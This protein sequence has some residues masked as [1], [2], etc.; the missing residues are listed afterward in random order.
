MEDLAEEFEEEKLQNA[1]GVE[2]TR[3]LDEP[4]QEVPPISS[5]LS[6]IQPP[7]EPEDEE[8]YVAVGEDEEEPRE[9]GESEKSEEDDPAIPRIEESLL[10]RVNHVF[11]EPPNYRESLQKLREQI[12]DSHVFIIHGDEHAGKLTCALHLA[13]DLLNRKA[14]EKRIYCYRRR[15][16]ELLSLLD[17][18][19]QE[20]VKDG[21]VYI[22]EDAFPSVS[23]EDLE[24]PFLH[25]LN[26]KLQ[27][28]KS[29]LLLTTE[30]PS[31]TLPPGVATV[32]VGVRDLQQVFL[33]H[34]DLY[35]AD[36]Y[37]VDRVRIEEP[38][39]ELARQSWSALQVDLKDPD[40]IDEFCR[41]L[42]VQG[43][44]PN[45]EGLRNLAQEI[46]LRR[47]EAARPWF[48]KLPLHEKLFAFLVILFPGRAGRSLYEIFLNAIAKLRDHGMNLIDPRE[49]G[50]DD[51]IDHIRAL[52]GPT[53]EISF[54][55]RTIGAEVEWQ[56]KNYNYLLWSLVPWFLEEIQRN[57]GREA[58]ES[59]RSWAAAVGRI[60]LHHPTQL[61]EK[62]E[63]LARH[64]AKG[65]AAATGYAFSEVCLR[66][67]DADQEVCD[68][69]RAW[70]ASRES[71]LMWTAS[72]CIWRVYG[73]LK[74]NVW[75]TS[76]TRSRLL[77]TLEG[78]IANLEERQP[79]GDE[80][81]KIAWTIASRNDRDTRAT[82]RQ[83]R[84]LL[85]SWAKKNRDSALF[86]VEQIAAVDP[87]GMIERLRLWLTGGRPALRPASLSA[88]RLLFGDAAREA[89]PPRPRHLALVALIEPV[90]AHCG[91]G[92]KATAALFN[93]LAKWVDQPVANEA[94]A[95]LLKAANRLTGRAARAFRA[96]LSPW[97]ANPSPQVRRLGGAL[98]TRSLILEGAAVPAL[99][100]FKGALVLDASTEA[101]SDVNYESIAR[102]IWNLLQPR[103]DLRL[104]R[105]G[106]GRELAG[107]GQLF[108]TRVVL[109]EGSR[110]RLLLPAIDAI[111]G[112]GLCVIIVLA[113]GP[114]LDLEEVS[115]AAWSS[116][117]LLASLGKASHEPSL[118]HAI[119]IDPRS[120]ESGLADL[121]ARVD[122]NFAAAIARVGAGAPGG[123]NLEAAL[124]QWVQE[125]DQPQSLNGSADRALAILHAILGLA[126]SD[127]ERCSA[128]LS[129]WLAPDQSELE[130]RTGSAGVRLL[131]RIQGHRS[132]P[133][134]SARARL[135][136]LVTKLGACGPE[137]LE[138]ALSAVR[139]WLRS[140]EWAETLLDDD[141]DE[142]AMLL[143]WIENLLPEKA[144]LVSRTL[145]DWRRSAN[146]DSAEASRRLI[147][148]A[149]RIEEWIASRTSH[150]GE[151]P[152]PEIDHASLLRVAPPP[153]VE[154][155]TE[156]SLSKAA[157]PTG[158][159][160]V[161]IE[162]IGA[163]MHWLPVTKI[164]FEKFIATTHDPLFNDTWYRRVLDLNPRVAIPEISAENYWHA[165]L[166]G[167]LP[168]E[169]Q[170]FAAWC[171]GDYALPTLTEWRKAYAALAAAPVGP[172][173]LSG[174]SEGAGEV[175]RSALTRIESSA[176]AAARPGRERT[177]ADQ[178]LLR[179]GVLEW[180]EQTGG[181]DRWG[182]MGEPSPH[183]RM[184]WS[185]DRG[186]A[187]PLNN[188]A[189]R[190]NVFGFRLIRRLG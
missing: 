141:R 105:M 58:G 137:G 38:I 101:I 74:R 145:A 37:A 161:W 134:A 47:I 140:E 112:E 69:L 94:M 150:P 156:V 85:K 132:P 153:A 190:S 128:L 48:A 187:I 110:P 91:E 77:D 113:T 59:R 116:S 62:L 15:P 57:S 17:F 81:W 33:K 31:R 20:N 99:G 138:T 126:E 10:E 125:L 109:G 76:E 151:E 88:I 80:D 75:D 124:M 177:R 28:K 72:S 60:G 169:A 114:I 7:E 9:G 130:L 179:L 146:E 159:P 97:L 183:F 106:E 56:L 163:F 143:Q 174:F 157:D 29:F 182:G 115:M 22:I 39:L 11:V 123:E 45:A 14:A 168:A 96:G 79:F 34:L 117:L 92:S 53:R 35:K 16:D 165:F 144:E 131:L 44:M 147:E 51:L 70:A 66:D 102:R 63:E 89:R 166:T 82:E 83:A 73:S 25:L 46:A 36:K 164:Q 65:V 118:P 160:M 148:A 49:I 188:G 167:I 87:E 61:R 170:Q 98:L 181:A 30:N 4:S 71:R 142:P 180:V 21:R 186:P 173:E 139:R 184:L 107:P 154:S 162:E 8:E 158:F 185:I 43:G 6:D 95:A 86:A 189:S 172:G 32:R 19:Q 3:E 42:G 171:G 64:P 133:P 50:Y 23:R 135:F 178:M 119:R 1:D 90:L 84:D 121:A 100:S 108:P 68:A 41:R 103:L 175:A 27:D 52:E 2:P 176:A 122:D 93:T 26:E 55:E 12:M 127:L 155:R 24:P 5:S 149:E 78:L 18:V 120:P 40:Q 152:A 67:R 136:S 111:G 104:V 129:R 13:Q 54:Q